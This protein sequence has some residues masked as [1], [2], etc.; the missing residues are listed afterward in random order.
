MD[1]ILLVIYIIILILWI[2][3]IFDIAFS[4]FKSNTMNL[5]WLVFVLLAPG[6]GTIFYLINKKKY[7]KTE[8]RKFNPKFKKYDE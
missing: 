3:S 7:I 2:Y 5:F 1:N 4:R 8:K 6:I